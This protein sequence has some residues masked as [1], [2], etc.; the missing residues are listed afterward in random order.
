MFLL[1]LLALFRRGLHTTTAV[2]SSGVSAPHHQESVITTI[3]PRGPPSAFSSGASSMTASESFKIRFIK[4]RRLIIISIIARFFIVVTLALCGLLVIFD[5]PM[6]YASVLITLGFSATVALTSQIMSTR[7]Q[8]SN[9]HS[10]SVPVTETTRSRG[11]LDISL[12]SSTIAPVKSTSIAVEA[13][14]ISL[15][16][17]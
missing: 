11:G 13:P 3:S 8:I 14:Q 5:S 9:D 15:P 7:V 17:H 10:S 1:Q 6:V 16:H 12:I 2:S 4:M